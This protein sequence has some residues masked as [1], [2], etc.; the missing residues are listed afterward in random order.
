MKTTIFKSSNILSDVMATYL[1]N[2]KI[3][4]Q[5]ISQKFRNRFRNCW[6]LWPART[7]VW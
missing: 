7:I 6:P 4:S 3:R 5:S 2:Q 1:A